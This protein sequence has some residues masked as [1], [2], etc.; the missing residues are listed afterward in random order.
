MELEEFEIYFDSLY[1]DHVC[2]IVVADELVQISDQTME[3]FIHVWKVSGIKIS[4]TRTVDEYGTVYMFYYE[5]N[6]VA[7]VNVE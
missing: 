7:V 1:L 3:L 2:R 6:V 4:I 5:N